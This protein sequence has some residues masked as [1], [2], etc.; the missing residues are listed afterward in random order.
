MINF[1]AK[2]SEILS[3]KTEIGHIKLQHRKELDSLQD[4]LQDVLMENR[5]LQENLTARAEVS[6]S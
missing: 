1:K 5:L 4:K 6:Y 2:E 3:L